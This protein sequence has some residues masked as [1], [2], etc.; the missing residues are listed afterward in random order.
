VGEEMSK[1][2][3]DLTGKTALV[4][5][6]AKGIGGAIS[7]AL[8]ENGAKVMAHYLMSEKA[9]RE[10]VKKFPN[11]SGTV[12]ADVSDPDQ[13]KRM[14]AEVLNKMGKIDIL[15]N[16]AGS[17]LKI[18]STEDMTLELWNKVL[19]LNLTSAM[20]CAKGVIPGMK[21]NSW[22]RIINISSISARSGGGPGGIAY[23]CSKGAMTTFTKGLAKELGA[24][25][26]TV[27]AI[28]PGVILTEI[29]E[30][31]NTPENLENLRKM[32]SLGR[33]GQPEDCAGT[34]VFLA[35]DSASY[36]TGATIAINGG[37]RMD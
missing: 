26:I 28:D 12:Q 2:K 15:V 29:H 16:N 32:T 4:T 24:F 9:A 35:S 3:A 33:L 21:K 5:G 14:M 1:V 23:A 36:I 6:G 19:A 31:F 30:K 20:I 27:N 8:A 37:L 25:G 34:V 17:Q 10:M 22:G 13:V 18:S 7:S 11:G